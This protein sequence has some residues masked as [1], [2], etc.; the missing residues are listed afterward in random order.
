MIIERFSQDVLN[1]GL[2]RVYIATG[3]FATL[4]FFVLNSHVFTPIEM[5]FGMV[6]MTIVLKALSN[7]MLSLVISLF[8]LDNKREEIDF[9]YNEEKID[10][11][12]N[13]LNL[14]EIEKSSKNETVKTK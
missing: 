10:A 12:L 6:C 11:M 2:F 9:R 1:T 3:F 4:I 7:I 5:I 8:S 14:K 13:E